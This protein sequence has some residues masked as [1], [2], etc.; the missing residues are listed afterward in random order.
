MLHLSKRNNI[1]TLKPSHPSE[2]I[3]DGVIKWDEKEEGLFTPCVSFGLAG[4][5]DILKDVPMSE[6]FIY[7]PV[8]TPNFREFYK[9]TAGQH[10]LSQLSKEVRVYNE[11]PVKKI[12]EFKMVYAN[13]LSYD[14][15]FYD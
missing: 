3:V 15:V 7:T 6:G 5:Q 1:K 9:E 10:E 8:R 4:V 14:I 12:G 11:V 2:D 13:G